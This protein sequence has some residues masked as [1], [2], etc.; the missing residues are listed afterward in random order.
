MT[1]VIGTV[2]LPLELA[3]GQRENNFKGETLLS[4]SSNALHPCLD[5]AHLSVWFSPMHASHS[6]NEHITPQA[7]SPSL[8]CLPGQ[9]AAGCVSRCELVV[10]DVRPRLAEHLVPWLW[11][12]PIR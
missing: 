11:C 3:D 7:R 1:P 9:S 8:V 10:R 6:M 5:K 2:H 4:V 12:H